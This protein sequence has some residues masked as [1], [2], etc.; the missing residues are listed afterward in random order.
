MKTTKLISFLNVL[1]A[2]TVGLVLALPVQAETK[3]QSKDL[4]VEQPADLPEMARTPGQSLFLYQAG[5]GQTYLYVE[6][7]EGARIAVFNVTHPAKITAAS[8]V[9]IDKPR[10]FDFVRALNDHSE[11]IRFRDS[12]QLAI[13]DLHN[14]KSPTLKIDHAL[15]QSGHT[16]ALGMTGLM[17]VNGS[18]S[19]VGHEAQDYEVVDDI[20]P[21]GPT[22]LATVKQVKHTVVNHETGTTYLLGSEGLT[23]VRRPRVE[24]DDQEHHDQEIN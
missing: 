3:S 10:T 2:A 7:Q 13:L 12:Q 17:I 14:P 4:I 15:N 22:S 9:V 19:Y 8:S 1:A 21:A 24:N 20:N 11:L 5:H 18:Y 16:E 23:V 6:Q